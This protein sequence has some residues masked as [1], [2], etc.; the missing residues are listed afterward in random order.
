MICEL[1]KKRPI[2]KVLEDYGNRR[3]SS[4]LCSSIEALIDLMA[5]ENIE[6]VDVE[7]LQGFLDQLIARKER[8]ENKGE[9]RTS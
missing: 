1:F 6:T 9:T 3:Y 5:D 8:N 4:G 7:F 2:D